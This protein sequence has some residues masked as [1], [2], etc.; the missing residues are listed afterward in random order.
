MGLA[1]DHN[2]QEAYCMRIVEDEP[3]VIQWADLLAI[4]AS[5]FVPA[6]V[7]LA[8]AG[9]ITLLAGQAQDRC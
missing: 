2:P 3:C 9:G 1:L 7:L 6:F 8:F 5:W 4:G